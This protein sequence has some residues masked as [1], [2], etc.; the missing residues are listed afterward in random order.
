MAKSGNPPVGRSPFLLGLTLA[1]ALTLGL[2]FSRSFFL[3]PL[4]AVEPLTAALIVHGLFGTAWFLMLCRQSWLAAK[5]RIAD[6][7]RAGRWGIPLAIAAVAS[8]LWVVAAKA[9]DGHRTGSGLPDTAGIL[10]QLST[11]TWFVV[12]VTLGFIHRRRADW[13][14]RLM[15]LATIAMMA[16][17]FSRITRLFRDSGPPAVDSAYLATFFIGALALYDWR[18]T[19][20]IHRVTLTVGVLYLAWVS[21]RLPIARSDW[22]TALVTPYL[23]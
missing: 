20:R 7:I 6:H 23:G 14:K 16:P 2:G 9:V 13:H 21:V 5:G 15:I 19:G 22:W 1:M 10:I 3:A 11:T 8:A 4:F 12:L 18:S 17:A